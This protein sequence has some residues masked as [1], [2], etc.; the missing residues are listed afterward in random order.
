MTV[1]NVLVF[2]IATVLLSF[3]VG[4]TGEIDKGKAATYITIIAWG[5][6]IFGLSI[7][8]MTL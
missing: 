1:F 6:L 4:R 7:G 8:R 3:L 5:S 2:A